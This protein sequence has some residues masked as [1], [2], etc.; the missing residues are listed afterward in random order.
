ML[1]TIC[2]QIDICSFAVSCLPVEGINWPGNDINP[3]TAEFF[4][5]VQKMID[6][7]LNV[8]E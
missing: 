3:D 8:H 1:K 4:D 6:S 7:N 2:K 5:K